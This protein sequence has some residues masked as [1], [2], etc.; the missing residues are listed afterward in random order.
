M[1]KKVIKQIYTQNA[2]VYTVQYLHSKH[3]DNISKLWVKVFDC[4]T[5]DCKSITAVNLHSTQHKKQEHN[6]SAS[7][8]TCAVGPL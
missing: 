1:T 4:N 2:A 5:T 8:D 3:H 7:T 6:R